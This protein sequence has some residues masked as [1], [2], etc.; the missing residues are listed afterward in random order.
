[1]ASDGE[2]FEKVGLG[3]EEGEELCSEC[4]VY[5]KTKNKY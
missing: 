3:K 4:K 1:M 2:G 5:L